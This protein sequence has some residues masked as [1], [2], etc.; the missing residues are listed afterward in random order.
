MKSEK[1][2]NRCISH[3]NRLQLSVPIGGWFGT[4]HVY[5]QK[6]FVCVCCHVSRLQ[7]S[8]CHVG[9]HAIMLFFMLF[10]SC[11]VHMYVLMGVVVRPLSKK[12]FQILLL[13]NFMRPK[14]SDDHFSKKDLSQ[15]YLMTMDISG[16][17]R[18]LKVPHILWTT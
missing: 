9:V 18:D 5:Q 16:Y 2:R 17:L 7:R 12:Y 14:T 3:I 1:V 13:C 15:S 4:L 6:K 11:R 10:V 8:M